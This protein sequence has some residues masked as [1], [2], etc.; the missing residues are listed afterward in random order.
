MANRHWEQNKEATV[1][2]GNLDERFTEPLMWE[3]MTQ[4]GPVVNVHMP[5][6]RVSRLHQGF[7]FVEFDT[8]E[9]ADYAARCLNGIRLFGKPVRIN[10]ASA[11]R[12][13]ATDIG[14]EL[15]VNNLDPQVDEKIL[16]DTFAQFG[17]LVAAPHVVRDANNVS[18]GYGFVNFDSFEASDTARDAMHGQYLLSKQVTVEYA[19]KK[20]GKGERHGDEAERKLA[21][22]GKKHNVMPEVHPWRPLAAAAAAARGPGGGGFPPQRGPI[23]LAAGNAPSPGGYAPHLRQGMA[24]PYGGGSPVGGALGPGGPPLPYQQQPP[25]MPAGFGGRGGLAPPMPYG[26]PGGAGM[27][28]GVVGGPGLSMAPNGLPARPPPG[29]PGGPL[30]YR[31]GP[32]PPPPQGFGGPAP[33]QQQHAMPPPGFGTGANSVSVPP[34]GLPGAGYN[35]MPPPPPPPAGFA[36]R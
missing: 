23:P 30:G 8:A 25:H 33:Q 26:P 9:S 22:E 2:V 3:L 21:A 12:Q 13:R 18:R 10:K 19:Y 4:M 29:G 16:Y 17:R 20:D 28:R 34:P 11:D 1:Y 32:P 31:G 7:G 27:G 24:P 5:M 35:G 36:R 14:A 6:D 15:F